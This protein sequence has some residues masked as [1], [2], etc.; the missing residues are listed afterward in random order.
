MTDMPPRPPAPSTWAQRLI[1]VHRSQIVFAAQPDDGPADAEVAYAVQ[2]L[3][4]NALAGEARPTA[5]KV[6]AA[7][8]D[9]EP[10]AASI[11]PHRLAFGTTRFPPGFFRAPA[12]E[13]EIA[14]RFGKDLPARVL[15]YSR[16]EIVDAIASAHVAMELVDTRLADAEAAGPWWRLAD[17]L[18]NGALVIG[19]EITDWRSLDFSRQRAQVLDGE[20]RLADTLGR[21]PLDDLFCCLPWWIAHVGGARSG[22][23]VTTG[24]WNGAHRVTAPGHVRV[25]FPG[26]GASSAFLEY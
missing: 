6:G 23:I 5:W 11:F 16:E 21:P 19:D 12:A 7:N 14:F 1:E 9:A 2:G 18:L 24:A 13:A 8:R 25:V 15:L 20:L 4:W 17:N 10:L 26:L 22:D 3:T